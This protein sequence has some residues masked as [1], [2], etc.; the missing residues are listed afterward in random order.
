MNIETLI[1][2][3]TAAMIQLT[4]AIL[5][6]QHPL[7]KKEEKPVAEVSQ[8]AVVKTPEVA[9]KKVEFAAVKE[10]IKKLAAEH[11]D[12][13][14]GL[15]AK[16]ALGVFDDI[17]LDKKDPSKGVKDEAKLASYYADL[18]ALENVEA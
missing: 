7:V 8:K 3:N 2:N 11:R 6:M 18:A 15:N 10:L 14:K 1:Q 9:A 16:Y 13:I 5:G 12:A 4:E 17:L